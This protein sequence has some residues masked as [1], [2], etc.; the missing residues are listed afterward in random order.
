L[1]FFPRA[2]KEYFR[3]NIMLFLLV[4]IVFIVGV[5]SGSVWVNLLPELQ[6]QDILNFV[7][8]FLANVNNISVEAREVFF[9]SLSNNLK[10][11]VII[12]VLG[13]TIFGFPLIFAV[14]FLRGFILGFAVGFLIGSLGFQ[15]ILVSILSILPQNI[16]I[17]PS[18]VLTAVAGIIFA[19]TVVKNRKSLYSEG[20]SQLITG[21]IMFNIVV[22]MFLVLSGLIEGYISPMVIRLLSGYS[23][24]KM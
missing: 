4:F 19:T 2:F 7:D 14:I 23:R 22:G 9:I 8:S 1:A 24:I 20:Y 5:A 15:G 18:L 3:K 16:I 6:R 21:Y 11:L 17:I 10:T 13:M 12:V